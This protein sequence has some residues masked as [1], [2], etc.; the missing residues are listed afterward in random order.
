MQQHQDEYDAFDIF[1]A[2]S[3]LLILFY[4]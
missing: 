3:Q 2:L 1:A 4:R